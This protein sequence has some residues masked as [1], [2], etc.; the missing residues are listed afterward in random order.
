MKKYKKNER[1]IL[2]IIF[3][4]SQNGLKEETAI[5][6]LASQMKSTADKD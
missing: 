6:Y 1:R 3:S 4:H 5:K 2:F